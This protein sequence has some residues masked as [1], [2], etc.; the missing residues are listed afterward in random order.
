MWVGKVSVA[1]LWANLWGP[2]HLLHPLL[3]QLLF[4]ARQ[5]V[6]MLLCAFLSIARPSPPPAVTLQPLIVED[7]ADA[8][9]KPRG[10]HRDM[11]SSEPH[12]AVGPE[13]HRQ[14]TVIRAEC[15]CTR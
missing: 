2:R 10:C 7:S 1:G 13:V 5:R 12:I 11:G 3:L 8:G 4:H 14:A 9:C 6:R 15:T